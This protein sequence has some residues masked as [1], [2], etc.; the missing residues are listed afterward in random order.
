MDAEK[1]G[2][3]KRGR[4]LGEIRDFCLSASRTRFPFF[5]KSL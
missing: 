1:D 3:G 5:K 4:G 2:E